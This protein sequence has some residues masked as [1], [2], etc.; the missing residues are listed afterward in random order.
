MYMWLYEFGNGKVKYPTGLRHGELA[1]I[2]RSKQPEYFPNPDTNAPALV[3]GDSNKAGCGRQRRQATKSAASTSTTTPQ[4]PVEAKA[5]YPSLT[6]F[7][8]VSEET[9]DDLSPAVYRK[10]ACLL[11]QITSGCLRSN[12]VKPL[13]ADLVIKDEDHKP[14]ISSLSKATGP[15]TPSRLKVRFDLNVCMPENK[16]CTSSISLSKIKTLSW[17]TTKPKH[18]AHSPSS[19][20]PMP[21]KNLTLLAETCSQISDEDIWEKMKALHESH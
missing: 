11:V 16:K 14:N 2:V 5:L 8:S 3:L 17:E 4:L 19:K 18:S 7:S 6:H 21:T 10:S 13:E 1:K 20:H 12:P 15:I 9:P